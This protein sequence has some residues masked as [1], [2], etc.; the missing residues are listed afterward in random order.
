MYIIYQISTKN[1]KIINDSFIFMTIFFFLKMIVVFG[2]CLY[3][4]N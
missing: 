3:A 4:L 1:F 2:L